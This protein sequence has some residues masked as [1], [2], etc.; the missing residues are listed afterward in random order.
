MITAA[1]RKA[2]ALANRAKWLDSE[3][4]QSAF[5][6][7]T[8]AMDERSDIGFLSVELN[9][10]NGLEPFEQ[11]ILVAHLESFEYFAEMSGTARLRI[12]WRYPKE[13]CSLSIAPEQTNQ[14]HE[15]KQ[16]A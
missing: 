12:E 5:T 4:G 2:Q 8:R 7:A 6:E 10:T 16:S 13:H 11:E 3:K 1:E 14:T 15:K 9:L